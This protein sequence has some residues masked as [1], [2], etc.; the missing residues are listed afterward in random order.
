MRGAAMNSSLVR[1]GVVRW[2]AALLLVLLAALAIPT[3]SAQGDARYFGETS[4]Y[5][6]GAFRY[7]WETHGGVR[8]FGF[9]V[10]EEFIRK[11]DGRIVQY[12]ERARFELTVNGNQA[13]VDLGRLGVETTGNKIFPRVPPF[14]SSAGLRYFPETQ[15]SLRGAFKATWDAHGGAPIFGLPI[16]EEIFEPLADGSWHLVQYFERVRFEL[17]PG[18]V[19]I[20][21]LGREL[22]PPQLLAPWPPEVAPPGP[23]SE[24]G[25]PGPPAVPPTGGSNRRAFIRVTPSSGKPGDTFRILGEGFVPGER[26]IMWVT[27]P[28][29]AIRPLGNVPAADGNGSISG[30]DISVTIDKRKQNSPDGF[31]YVTAQGL[32]SGRIG[33]GVFGIGVALPPPPPPPAP[34]G[35]P[36]RLGIIIHTF[37]VPRGA[38]SITPLA[39]AP[40]GTFSFKASG[41]DPSE[42]VGVWLTRPNGAGQEEIATGQ[43]GQDGRGN[44][45]VNFKPAVSTEGIW[46]ITGQGVKTGRSVTAPFKVTRDYV[47]PVGTRRPANRSGSVIPA[48]GGRSTVFSLSGTGFQANEPLELWIT[49]P[50][51]LYIL[52]S[53]RADGRGRIGYSPGLLVQFGAQNPTGV[54][55]YHYRGTRSDRRVDLYFTY[56]GS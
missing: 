9:P 25:R 48:Q 19:L 37:L 54:Y 10:T 2:S 18:G 42:R 40:G 16:S 21:L 20:G 31:Y 5:L 50:D 27:Y 45:T 33:I 41:F 39:A 46:T 12:F 29:Q 32:S 17:W 52:A 34:S 36:N 13:I 26:V 14:R 53:A 49:S 51:G 22:A 8:T 6:R 47:A 24:E 30:A 3:A 28:N 35:D 1:R 4:H 11:S 55:G 15:H 56:T 38:G 7:F 23:L 44:I 43:I